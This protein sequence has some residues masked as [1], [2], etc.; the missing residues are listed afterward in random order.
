MSAFGR[1]HRATP[2]SP[3]KVLG[4]KLQSSSYRPSIRRR[5][6]PEYP[7]RSRSRRRPPVDRVFEEVVK[8]SADCQALLPPSRRYRLAGHEIADV[9]TGSTVRRIASTSNKLIQR[10]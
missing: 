6:L 4:S 3:S 8:G 9:V 10:E 1:R 7:P 5:F 2:G